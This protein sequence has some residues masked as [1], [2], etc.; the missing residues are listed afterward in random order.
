MAP[1]TR[2]FRGRVRSLTARKPCL[3]CH[4]LWTPSCARSRSQTHGTI[5]FLAVSNRT[6]VRQTWDGLTNDINSP[7][8]S[9]YFLW[10]ESANNCEP[11][12]VRVIILMDVK[13]VLSMLLPNSTL[14]RKKH[15]VTFSTKRSPTQNPGTSR[16]TPRNRRNLSNSKSP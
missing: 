8:I 13:I 12:F 15:H 3:D 11:C 6:G 2:G 1:S 9:I 4:M 5:D 10:G 7:T 16:P 14:Q